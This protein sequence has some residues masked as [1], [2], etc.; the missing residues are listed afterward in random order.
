MEEKK[1][2]NFSAMLR[3]MD[4]VYLQKVLHDRRL[5]YLYE[6]WP[7]PEYVGEEG[8][9]ELD[10][11]LGALHSLSEAVWSH[12]SDHDDTDTIY[13]SHPVMMEYY[14]L[15]RVYGKHQ[16]VR[17]RDNPYMQR[18]ADFVRS[19]LHQDGCFTC[20]YRLQTKVN[21]RWAS[22]VVFRMWPEFYDHLALLVQMARV[23]DFYERELMRLKTELAE[24]QKPLSQ[25]QAK[26]AA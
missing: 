7:P 16:G 14:R 17:L 8:D 22:G 20:S 4:S 21:H 2:R 9:Y 24:F 6:E 11:I 3:A 1:H 13:F 23:L 18:A 26:E 12:Y 15:C 19:R 5:M 10:I 25:K